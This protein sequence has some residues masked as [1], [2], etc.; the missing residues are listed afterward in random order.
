MSRMLNS[1]VGSRREVSIS[2][3]DRDYASFSLCET[4]RVCLSSRVVPDIVRIV[5]MAIQYSSK[6]W[7]P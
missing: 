3:R 6:E 1:A 5:K 2:M 4:N 7:P